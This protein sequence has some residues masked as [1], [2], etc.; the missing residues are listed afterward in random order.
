L[1]QS[2][3]SRTLSDQLTADAGWLER[4]DD[5]LRSAATSDWP[6]TK[7]V[8]RA[9]YNAE[10]VNGLRLGE[11][12]MIAAYLVAARDDLS[13]EQI[14]S[15]FNP[16]IASL[17]QGVNRMAPIAALRSATSAAVGQRASDQASQLEALR[18]MLLA[19]VQDVR[20]VLI[21]LADATSNLRQLA[22]DGDLGERSAAAQEA[23]ALFAPLANRL[24]VW[25][26]KWELEDLALRCLD[27]DAYRGI[28]ARLDERRPDRESY[29]SRVTA[30]LRDEL[31]QTGLEGEVYGRPKHIYSIFNKMQKKNLAFEDLFDVRAVRVVVNGIP[32]CYTVLGLVHQIWS[33]IPREFDDY[34]AKPKP[35]GYRSL[36]T[37]VVGP[38]S[39]ILEVQI[40]TRDMHSNAE[41]GVAA[42][43]RYKE[44][45]RAESE[46]DR[47][48]AW[49]R[50]VME[51][52]NDVHQIGDLAQLFR[53]EL[54]QDAVYVLTPQGRVIDLPRGATPIDFAYHVHT[55]LGHRCRGARVNGVMVPL[56]HGLGNGD[57]V[58][59][60]LGR[61]GGPSRDWLN[62]Q[63]N[64]LHS[65]RARA[66]VRH[67]FNAQDIHRTE[68][69]GREI[70]ERESH[71]VGLSLPSLEEMADR[72]QLRSVP[73]ML[74]AVARGEINS[75]QIQTTLRNT[76]KVPANA[77][78]ALTVRAE[79]SH[80]TLS[81]HNAANAKG[82][83]IVGV[84]RLLTVLAKCCKPIPPDPIVGFVSK[85][86][87]VS[88]HRRSCSNV[89]R[90]A[91]ERM[92]EAAWGAQETSSQYPVE[93]IIETEGL[94]VP[95]REVLDIFIR[96]R[97][98]IL[99]SNSESR[100]RMALM[101]FTIEVSGLA[102]LEP[103]LKAIRELPG[104]VT[105]HRH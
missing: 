83:L 41:F 17:V 79:A 35:N 55:D 101:R 95:L 53:A 6:V 25:Q 74:A 42:H 21:K 10:I 84:D 60:I 36:H 71:R 14:Q 100:D 43:W 13:Q 30:L 96:E 37:A 99:A 5:L 85:G 94:T 92:I 40:R 89:T 59:I 24:G 70:L 23:L 52:R 44:S 4:A 93:V 67:W 50:Q 87:G 54:F 8:E 69:Q 11:E 80:G 7:V 82:I 27:P 48:I 32:D 62:P 39:K 34:I 18:K 102:H 31:A 68:S 47:K 22:S 75:R 88:V 98:R 57:R 66:K 49:L 90:L 76:G 28:A 15:R 45:A 104:V 29:I 103:V 26:I 56:S 78:S 65:N 64:Y 19:M 3:I 72:L 9:R 51:W 63:L 16:D 46:Y 20:V 1:E 105:V 58:E 12:C 77:V 33:P 86:R 2:V 81:H 61:E 97:V 73:D 91:G 38:D